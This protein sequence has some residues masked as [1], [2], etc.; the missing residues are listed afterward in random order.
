MTAALVSRVLCRVLVGLV[1]C[2]PLPLAAQTLL[3]EEQIDVG[4]RDAVTALAVRGGRVFTAAFGFS[5]THS[6][7]AVHALDATGV[8]LWHEGLAAPKN[9]AG[10]FPPV[11]PLALDA[12]ADTL[13][14]VG[15]I[16]GFAVRVYD[17][18]TGDLRWA[19]RLNAG[20]ANT[21]IVS[22]QAVYVGGRMGGKALLRAYAL[23][24][25][26]PVARPGPHPPRGHPG[27]ASPDDSGHGH[28]PVCCPAFG[29]GAGHPGARRH[30][31]MDHP[32]PPE[33]VIVASTLAG[34]RVF[35]VGSQAGRWYVQALSRQTGASLWSQHTPASDREEFA[36]TL[37]VGDHVYVGGGVG[38]GP[39]QTIIRGYRKTD[40]APVWY[41]LGVVEDAAGDF[42][43]NVVTALAV[44]PAREWVYVGSAMLNTGTGPPPEFPDS[45]CP[46]LRRGDGDAWLAAR[47]RRWPAASV[48]RHPGPG[49]QRRTALRR[50][51]RRSGAGG[52]EH[53][54]CAGAGLYVCPGGG[55]GDRGRRSAR[56]MVLVC[57]VRALVDGASP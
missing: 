5:A 52:R 51:V 24:W 17:P 18:Q 46:A 1:L 28:D 37:A 27:R 33:T 13:A 3:W 39:I 50:G 6:L 35:L 21:V 29:R 53:A 44:D 48:G 25:H 2:L 31:R 36:T 49:P 32:A 7:W 26:P 23:G 55:H 10:G 41:A 34:S 16:R 20:R 43:E 56:L 38:S 30:G 42:D 14:V 11:Q 4:E 15:T 40:G 8:P 47:A 9:A 19:D 45:V 57:H 22:Q 54:E 12:T